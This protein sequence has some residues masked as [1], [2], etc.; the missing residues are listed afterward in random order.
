MIDITDTK[1][2]FIEPP[3][4]IVASWPPER[5]ALLD[6]VRSGCAELDEA[7]QEFAD[8][9]AEMS[10]TVSAIAERENWIKEHV[11]TR[12]DALE[13]AR[14]AELRRVIASSRTQ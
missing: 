2:R 3:A 11:N 6:A 4:D 5:I 8:L 12:P 9:Q 1:G 13:N 7:E 14:V 10:R